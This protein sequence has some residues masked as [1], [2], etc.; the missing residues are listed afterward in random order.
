ML[1]TPIPFIWQ[2]HMVTSQK[3]LVTGVLLL[4]LLST[5][6]AVVRLAFL[7]ID[8]YETKPGFRDVL[9]IDT[10]VLVWSQVEAGIAIVAACLPTLRPLFKGNSPESLINSLRSVFSLQSLES[11]GSRRGSRNRERRGSDSEQLATTA[12][13]PSTLAKKASRSNAPSVATQHTSHGDHPETV[14]IAAKVQQR[15]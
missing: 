4:G 2:L 3:L 5:A 9:G 10:I 8:G 11:G 1:A 13:A 14:P 7:T 12:D 15:I 6:S